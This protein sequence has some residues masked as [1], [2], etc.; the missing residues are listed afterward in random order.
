MVEKQPNVLTALLSLIMS[1][2]SQGWPYLAF[3]AGVWMIVAS[4]L[5]EPSPACR[6]RNLTVA[7]TVLLGVAIGLIV[8][9]FLG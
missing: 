1:V 4:Q 5:S 7:G 3:I 8:T 6:V 2:A 9:R